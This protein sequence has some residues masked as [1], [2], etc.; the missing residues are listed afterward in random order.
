[1]NVY[2]YLHMPMPMHLLY[3]Y[4]YANVSV[5]VCIYICML[6]IFKQIIYNYVSYHDDM[7]DTTNK[8]L[9]KRPAAAGAKTPTT[10]PV[11]V[12]SPPAPRSSWRR[13]RPQPRRRGAT[14]GRR[15]GASLITVAFCGGR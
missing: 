7:R 9:P 1:M 2:M 3:V 8:H 14:R 4:V 15:P 10:A 11:P 6:Y 12:A 13:R 5:Y